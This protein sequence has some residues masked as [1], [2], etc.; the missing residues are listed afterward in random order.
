MLKVSQLSIWIRLMLLGLRDGFFP[1][2]SLTKVWHCTVQLPVPR[3]Y[4]VIA[5]KQLTTKLQIFDVWLYQWDLARWKV[6]ICL[7]NLFATSAYR[8]TAGVKQLDKVH[9]T[10]F[11]A[12]QQNFIRHLIPSEHSTLCSLPVTTST[13]PHG[14][15]QWRKPH[16]NYIYY[17]FLMFRENEL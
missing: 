17:N 11:Q 5:D 16:T 9:V 8:I 12:Q 7:I 1:R 4:L 10:A 14:N 13:M 15:T 6:L 2:W 3:T